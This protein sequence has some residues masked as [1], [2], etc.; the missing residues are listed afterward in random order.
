MHGLILAAALAIGAPR[1][2]TTLTVPSGTRLHLEN[3]AGSI[4]VKTWT[5]G[6]VRIQASHGRRTHIEFQQDGSDLAVSAEVDRGAP[7]S[8]DYVLTVPPWVELELSGVYCDIFAA[9]LKGEIKAETVQGDV[10]LK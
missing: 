10:E 2:D 6:V 8:V 1:T 4:E 7:G 3:F 5:R 9:G